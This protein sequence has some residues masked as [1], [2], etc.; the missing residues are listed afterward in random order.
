MGKQPSTVWTPRTSRIEDP[1]H[2]H[3]HK[4]LVTLCLVNLLAN[5]AYSSI[6]PFYPEEAIR[7]G[8]PESWLGLVFSSYSIAM[9]VFAP[10]FARLLFTVGCKN[11]LVLGCICEGISM[12]IFGL[13]Y[14]LNGATT[15]AVCSFLCRM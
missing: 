11:V 3:A 7:K 15:Y 5:S 10:A 8:V 14:Y 1:Q 4:I 13:F 9:V 12:I 2:E 6:A